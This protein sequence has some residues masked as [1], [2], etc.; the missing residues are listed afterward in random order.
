MIWGYVLS[1]YELSFP[2]SFLRV[3]SEKH[4]FKFFNEVQF[5]SH[6]SFVACDFCVT[7][8]KWPLIPNHAALV[9]CFPLILLALTSRPVIHC[10]LNFLSWMMSEPTFTHLHEDVQL[11]LKHWLERLSFPIHMSCCFCQKSIE[12]KCETSFLISPFYSTHLHPCNDPVFI[13]VPAEQL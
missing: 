2:F 7:S 10:E 4:V 9:F 11:S 3:C 12:H 13:L 6:F 8:R 5:R 1:F